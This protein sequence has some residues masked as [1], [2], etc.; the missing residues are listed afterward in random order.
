MR[1]VIANLT[2]LTD[3]HWTVVKTGFFR[4]GRGG[5]TELNSCRGFPGNLEH[6]PLVAEYV[7]FIP[8]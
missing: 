4:G 2:L 3:F 6:A 1:F 7:T 5:Q 8:R